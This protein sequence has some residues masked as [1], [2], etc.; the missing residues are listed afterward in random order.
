MPVEQ[1][2]MALEA[3]GFAGTWE[4]RGDR[5]VLDGAAAAVL[6]GDP[7]RAGKEIDAQELSLLM[8]PEDRFALAAVLARSAAQGGM[9]KAEYAVRTDGG[10]RRFSERGRFVPDGRGGMRGVGVLLEVT[11]D[12]GPAVPEPSLDTAVD[13]CIDLRHHIDRVPGRTAMMGIL[14]DMLLMEFGLML[15]RRIGQR[16]S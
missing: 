7:D 16:H 5:L 9:H 10:V 12:L 15:G 1:S 4:R 8:G 6:L 2:Q 11:Q 3:A 14:V 13:L